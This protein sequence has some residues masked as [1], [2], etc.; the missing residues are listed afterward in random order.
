MVC[1][2]ARRHPDE[3]PRTRLGVDPEHLHAHRVAIRRLRAALREEPLKTELGWI[4]G[5]LGAVRDLDVLTAHLREESAGLDGA[6]RAALRPVLA[7]LARRFAQFTRPYRLPRSG[8]WH[9]GSKYRVKSLRSDRYCANWPAWRR[10]VD[11]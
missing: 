5:A 6:E 2:A 4:G 3:R 9:E 10:P 7:R 1:R 11:R 8:F